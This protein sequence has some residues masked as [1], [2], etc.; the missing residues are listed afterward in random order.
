MWTWLVATWLSAPVTID[1]SS[2]L[3]IRVDRD[4]STLLSGL[5]HNHAIRAGSFRAAATLDS[6][7]G[8]CTFSVEIPVQD[9]RVDE[10]SMRRR[11]QLEGE[12]DD[13]DREDIRNNML[14]DDQLDAEKYP[15]I[16]LEA[17]YCRLG[18]SSLTLEGKLSIRGVTR[19]IKARLKRSDVGERKTRLKGSIPVRATDFGFEP[20]SAALG[21]LKNRDE[22]R[23]HIEL[24]ASIPP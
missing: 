2:L 24:V 1:P 6:D 12:L 7:S 21:S 4:E 3:V 13:D 17:T 16:R 11:F 20:Y 9:L 19:A 23:I 18:S 14:A 22:M 15:E 5:S 10:P 8:K